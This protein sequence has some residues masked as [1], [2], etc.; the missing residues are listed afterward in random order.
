MKQRE[1]NVERPWLK[2]VVPGNPKEVEIPII[3]LPQLLDESIAK[4]PNHTA[5]TFFGKT[6]SYKELNNTIQKVAKAL[7]KNGV[8]KGDRV[9]IML[10][11]CPQYPMSFYSILTCGAIV[12]QVNPMYKASELIHILNDS[13]A[14]IIIVMDQL[15]P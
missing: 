4:Y 3:S 10:P 6:F 11:N 8:G 2:H 1:T 15:L 7:S 12:V 9:A 5:M 14:K 13:G